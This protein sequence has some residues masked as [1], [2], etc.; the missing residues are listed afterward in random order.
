MTT[1]DGF[2]KG[3]TR[4]GRLRSHDEDGY[5]PPWGSDVQIT[6]IV[7]GTAGKKFLKM[8]YTNYAGEQG[9]IF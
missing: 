2:I 3:F 4:S 5:R 1:C 9:G 6:S 7:S 8:E